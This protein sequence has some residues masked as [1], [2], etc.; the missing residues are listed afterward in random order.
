LIKVKAGS[1]EHNDIDSDL[2]LFGLETSSKDLYLE[3]KTKTFSVGLKI[4]T[5]TLS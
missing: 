2:E 4:N 5:T 3:T 1:Q